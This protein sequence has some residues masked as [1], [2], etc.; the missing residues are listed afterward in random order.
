MTEKWWCGMIRSMVWWW[1]C[2]VRNCC[3]SFILFNLGCLFLDCIHISYFSFRGDT[4]DPLGPITTLVE[5]LLLYIRHLPV[6]LYWL[7]RGTKCCTYVSIFTST[8]DILRST[9]SYVC[10]CYT[11]TTTMIVYIYVLRSTKYTRVTS[12]ESTLLFSV[13]ECFT[14]YLPFGV[15]GELLLYCCTAVSCSRWREKRG[16][17]KKDDNQPPASSGKIQNRP[18]RRHTT[19]TFRWDI[20]YTEVLVYREFWLQLL[21]VLST[22][23][24]VLLYGTGSW[25]Y[26]FVFGLLR[27]RLAQITPEYYS[28]II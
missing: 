26:A 2:E 25:M 6:M 22:W 5:Y 16:E 17:L 13:S 24:F 4:T 1:S 7:D 3:P 19:P 12:N 10:T 18:T 8:T 28:V 23:C 21:S 20:P 15:L 11:G 14:L 27:Q 9:T